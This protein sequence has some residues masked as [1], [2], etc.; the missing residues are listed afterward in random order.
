MGSF[1]SNIT[2]L[3]PSQGEL[4]RFLEGA[5]RVSY[6]APSL[7]GAT[8]VFDLESED[9]PGILPKLAEQISR[10]FTCPALAIL[11]HDDDVL[12]YDLFVDGESVDEYN[13]APTYFDPNAEPGPPS[14]GDADRLCRVFHAPDAVERVAEILAKSS[15]DD[16]GYVFALDRHQD[17]TTVLGLPGYAVGCGYSSIEENELPDNLNADSLVRSGQ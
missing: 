14:G 1:Y 9:D 15:F 5:H 12:M 17:L 6:I 16:D 11:N 4:C 8:V 2:V 7:Q 13:S 3:G 10:H